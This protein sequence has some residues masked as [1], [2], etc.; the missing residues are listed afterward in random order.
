MTTSLAVINYFYVG[1]NVENI[2]YGVELTLYFK[3]MCILLSKRGMRKKSNIFY[4][5]FSSIMLLLITIWIAA[6]AIFGQHMW[7]LE[8]DFPGGAT[9]YWDAHLA[10]WYMELSTIVVVLLQLMTDALMIHRCRIVWNSY[11]VVFA[12]IILWVAT[13]IL[14]ALVAW[15]TSFPGSDYY[16]GAGAKFSL[17]YWSVSVFLNATLTCMI[18]YRLVRHG[19]RVQECLG[20]EYASLYF[21]VTAIIVESVLPYTL[22]GII[23]LVT[24]GV[25]NKTLLTLL[26]VYFL[27]MCISPQMLILRVVMGKACNQDTFN[28]PSDSTIN[29]NRVRE[30]TVG[31]QSFESS[32]AGVNLRKLSNVYLL[33]THGDSRSSHSQV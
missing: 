7:I 21:T 22:S 29:F 11:R 6:Q 24:L 15:I 26:C 3:T 1:I 33:D 32:G 17:A 9:A 2:L 30:N 18:C 5:L 25:G 20:N 4:A 14:G 16:T 23:F 8:S 28:R 10:V 12:P 31:S 13:L 19:R 27:M